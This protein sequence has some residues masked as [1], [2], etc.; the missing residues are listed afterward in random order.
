MQAEQLVVRTT[1]A[2]YVASFLARYTPLPLS[3]V[4]ATLQS[5]CDFASQ[6]AARAGALVHRTNSLAGG[7]A[8]SEHGACMRRWTST[9]GSMPAMPIIDWQQHEIFYAVTQSLMYI[10]CYHMHRV[11]GPPL[12][13]ADE[14]ALQQLRELISGKVVPLVMCSLQPLAVCLPTV[15]REFSKQVAMCQLGEISSTHAAGVR[16]NR[17]FEMFFP[18]DPYLLPVSAPHLHL[19]STYRI[20]RRGHVVGGPSAGGAVA[21]GDASDDDE[22]GDGASDGDESDSDL[23]RT[24]EEGASPRTDVAASVPGSS[25]PVPAAPPRAAPYN[26]FAARSA[27]CG[28]MDSQPQVVASSHAGAWGHN[29]SST[30]DGYLYGH[31]YA[32]SMQDALGQSPDGAVPM[33]LSDGATCG[34]SSLGPGRHAAASAVA[35]PAVIHTGWPVAVTGGAGVPPRADEISATAWAVQTWH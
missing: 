13:A 15:S 12:V 11:S 5:L 16:V 9:A 20:W 26:P 28:G 34:P 1:C 19:Q 23:G 14:A 7:L 4:V 33:S 10:L 3:T 32:S 6:Y 25:G 21:G 24:S 29:A 30:S 31:S 17:R 27:A 18:F 35:N 8:G 2:A 22:D